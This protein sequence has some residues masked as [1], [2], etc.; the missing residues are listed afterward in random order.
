MRSCILAF[1]QH[2]ANTILVFWAFQCLGVHCYNDATICGDVVD[3]W[4]SLRLPWTVK[5][6]LSVMAVGSSCCIHANVDAGM[7]CKT[8]KDS[9]SNHCYLHRC[10]CRVLDDYCREANV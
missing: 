1:H 3:L 2:R 7:N 6:R 4:E 8:Q 10:E 5:G 9:P